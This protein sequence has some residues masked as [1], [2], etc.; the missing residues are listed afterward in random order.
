MPHR[1]GGKN[2]K[3]IAPQIFKIFKRKK[4]TVANALK[5]DEWIKKLSNEATLSIEHITQFVQ[6]WVLIQNVHLVEDVEKTLIGSLI[7]LKR[8]YNF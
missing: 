5:E 4:W 7:R 2:P 6:L 3:D 8:I 1:F